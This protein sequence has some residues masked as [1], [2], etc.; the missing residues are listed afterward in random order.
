M[1]LPTIRQLIHEYAKFVRYQ[2]GNLWY[3][4]G[5][6]GEE[7][8]VSPAS[9]QTYK[10]QTV[11]FFDFPVPI[12]DTGEGSF[13]TMEKAIILMRWIRK[14]L[15]YLNGALAEGVYDQ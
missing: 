9:G 10:R 8:A 3:Q 2:D 14:H 13:G 15:E 11:H 5:W 4:I 7:D 1:I 12:D 6:N